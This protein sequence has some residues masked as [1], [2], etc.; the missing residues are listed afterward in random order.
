ML[1]F[2]SIF[3]HRENYYVYLLQKGDLTFAAKIIDSEKTKELIRHRE[4]R[5]RSPKNRTTE[6]PVYCFVVLTT[7]DFENQAAHYGRPEVPTSGEIFEVISTLNEKD[8]EALKTEIRR[9]G[10]VN[11]ALRIGIDEIY[12][13]EEQ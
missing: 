1:D 6:Q 2:G 11:T 12:P 4:T 9:D 8:L 10:A 13:E 5:S 7:S 3:R